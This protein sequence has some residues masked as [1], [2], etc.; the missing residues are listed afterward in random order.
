[1]SFW[2]GYEFAR[3][4]DATNKGPAHEANPV[5]AIV[6][7]AGLASNPHAIDVPLDKLRLL[8]SRSGWNGGVNL[9]ASDEQLLTSIYG[10]IESYL[11]RDEPILKFDTATLREAIRTRYSI[12]AS[13]TGLFWKLFSS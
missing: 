1:L 12:Q 7:L 3:I 11:V 8:T 6:Y 4:G 2:A 13:D 5:D 10:E 9:S